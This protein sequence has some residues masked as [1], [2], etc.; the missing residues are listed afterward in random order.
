MA[1]TDRFAALDGVRGCAVL[2]VVVAHSFSF[3]A[4]E[5]TRWRYWTPGSVGVEVFFVLSGFLIAGILWR[6]RERGEDVRYIWRAFLLRR[7]LRIFPLAYVALLV[8]WLIGMPGMRQTPI[9]YLTYTT[10]W[11]FVDQA[12][13]DPDSGH[14][15]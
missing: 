3:A 6:A 13:F 9:P 4:W 11:H 10:N 5:T 8:C 2:G 15:C 12:R 7:A 14:F 1:D